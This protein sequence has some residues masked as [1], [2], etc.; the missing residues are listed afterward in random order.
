MRKNRLFLIIFSIFLLLPGLLFCSCGKKHKINIMLSGGLDEEYISS[1]TLNKTDD[2]SVTQYRESI[3]VSKQYQFEIVYKNGYDITDIY[4]NG[5]D[6]NV[7][8]KKIKGEDAWW[9]IVV[10][11]TPTEDKTYNLIITEP[12]KMVE[13]V[14][15]EFEEEGL[16]NFGRD[17]MSELKIYACHN[18]AYD[19]YPLTNFKEDNLGQYKIV[20]DLTEQKARVQIKMPNMLTNSALNKFLSI[21]EGMYFNCAQDNND[22]CLY[23]FSINLT[24]TN[25]TLFQSNVKLDFELLQDS[26]NYLVF[27]IN[28]EYE[29]DESIYKF[30]LVSAKEDEDFKTNFKK[31]FGKAKTYKLKL[32]RTHSTQEEGAVL[33]MLDLSRVTVYVG[34]KATATHYDDIEDVLTFTLQNTDLPIDYYINDN[35]FNFSVRNL[36]LKNGYLSYAIQAE[37]G[38]ENSLYFDDEKINEFKFD[39]NENYVKS[40]I[41]AS[42]LSPRNKVQF[43]SNYNL[44]TSIY[45]QINISFTFMGN[46]YTLNEVDILSLLNSEEDVEFS[47]EVMA[48]ESVEGVVTTIRYSVQD[49]KVYIDATYEG[50]RCSS[51]NGANIEISGRKIAFSLEFKS[52]DFQTSQWEYAQ[53]SS[54][55]GIVDDKVTVYASKQ[56]KIDFSVLTTL[57]NTSWG[58]EYT[59]GMKITYFCDNK[60]VT[61]QTSIIADNGGSMSQSNDGIVITKKMTLTNGHYYIQNSEGQFELITK[62][63]CDFVKNL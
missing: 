2:D 3:V 12:R 32:D 33:N 47:D 30:K 54:L 22:V 21:G 9:K 61:P 62:I 19:F 34:D 56:E 11:F 37:T 60:E 31:T 8:V 15:V 53:T 29:S 36:Q 26:Q 14:G 16:E 40:S 18:N 5:T 52:S 49:K 38:F 4:I 45:S 57:Q 48:S 25:Y 10:V 55:G 42:G 7:E 1:I 23:T 13:E 6:K 63:I 27:D 17:L 39:I 59:W 41:Y 50:N 51:F 58:N 46:N 24:S 43:T 35:K 20:F 44:L 28:N